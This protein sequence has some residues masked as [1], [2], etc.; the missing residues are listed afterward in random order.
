MLAGYL[1][2]YLGREKENYACNYWL[3]CDTRLG[4]HAPY[5]SVRW[6]VVGGIWAAHCTRKT[7]FVNFQVPR[8]LRARARGQD[9]HKAGWRARAK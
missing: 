8:P 1:A 7:A 3:I 9:I 2:T 5:D 6:D 4:W